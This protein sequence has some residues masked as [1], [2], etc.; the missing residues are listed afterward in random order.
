[1]GA[2]AVGIGRMQGLALAAG[3]EAGVVRALEL[4]ED[5]VRR[6]LGLLGVTSFA[7][8]DRRYVTSTAPLIRRG[9]DS[10]FPLLKEGY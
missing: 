10:P 4:I 1:M 2:N 9:I 6:V 7:Q 3:G 8:L 5:E